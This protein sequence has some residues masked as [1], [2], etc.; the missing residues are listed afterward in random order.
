MFEVIALGVLNLIQVSGSHVVA[1]CV[2]E[3]LLSINRDCLEC[4]QANAAHKESREATFL[5]GYVSLEHVEFT[6]RES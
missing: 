3:H 6:L 2:F 5:F 1:Y 4:I